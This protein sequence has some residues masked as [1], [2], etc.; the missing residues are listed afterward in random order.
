MS[1]A[2]RIKEFADYKNISIRSIELTSGYTLG[3]ISSAIKRKG[4]ITEDLSKFL[5][6]YPEVNPLWI[7]EGKG[8]MLV[9]NNNNRTIYTIKS[10]DTPVNEPVEEYNSDKKQN[11]FTISKNNT[12]YIPVSKVPDFINSTPT[13]TML[14]NYLPINLP[15]DFKSVNYIFQVEGENMYPT[16]SNGDNV[17]CRYLEN[18]KYI[19]FGDP[20]LLDI[21]N[22]GLLLR[23]LFKSDNLNHVI[24]R[25]DNIGY[26]DIE[27]DKDDILH[28]FLVTTKLS[29][30]VGERYFEKQLI[31]MF[32]TIEQLSHK[33]LEQK[34]S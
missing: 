32:S 11:F 33:I 28:L 27:V 9:D 15:P 2:L 6:K 16:F 26:P 31:S 21:G 7:Y 10:N 17:G 8:T 1:K 34:A 23:R 19:Q 4:D 22:G 3:I 29:K 14:N 12:Y 30:N 24:L 25:S 5:D 13:T 18:K 20:H